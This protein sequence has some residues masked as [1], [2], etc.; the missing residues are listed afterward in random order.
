MMGDGASFSVMVG[1]GETYVPAFALAIGLGEI[2]AGLVSTLPMLAGGILQLATPWGVRWLGSHRRWVVAN[3]ISQAM[4]LLLMLPLALIAEVSPWL[5]FL[6]AT[7]YWGTGLATGPAWNAWVEQLVPPGVRAKFFANRTRLCHVGVLLGL[8]AGG[9]LLRW[10][11]GGTATTTMFV[12]MFSIAATSRLFSAIMLARQSEP[13]QQ[14]TP[15]K[16]EVTY[17]LLLRDARGIAGWRLVAY[18][19][20]VQ[21]AVH[22]VAPFFTPFM[23]VQL[24]LSYLQYMLLLACGFVG[25]VLALPWA[26]RLA[27]QAGA[28]RLLWIGSLAIVPLSALWIISDAIPFLIFVQIVGGMAWAMFELAMLL[29]FFESIPR[30]HR[31]EMLSLYN[32]GNAVAMVTGA[33]LGAWLLSVLGEGRAPYYALFAISAAGRVVALALIPRIR[34]I[35]STAEFPVGLRP[36]AVRPMSGGIERP[37]LAVGQEEQA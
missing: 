25:K 30:S 20:A 35:P 17:Q 10:G 26:G 13:A 24:E 5:V 21:V 11:E 34:A 7:L 32:L 27:K 9:I 31:L 16:E 12:V 15:A 37:I 33:L 19:L 1:I 8:V 6:P 2:A 4:S 28:Q 29:M 3:A 22:L 36:I 23:L 14:P 18:L